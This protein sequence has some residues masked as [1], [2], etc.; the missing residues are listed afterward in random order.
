LAPAEANL[1]M[2]ESGPLR[3]GLFPEAGGRV[4]LVRRGDGPNLL[5][6]DPRQW[7]PWRVPAPRADAHFVPFNGHMTW[8]SPQSAW[9]SQQTV[10]E[11]RL[12]RKAAWPP[13]PFLVYGR[14]DVVSRE[15]GAAV[16][17]S[18]T[19][20]VTGLSMTHRVRLLCGKCVAF[21]AEAVNQR[22]SPVT[23]GLWSNTRVPAHATIVV[24]VAT[25]SKFEL[26]TN[27]DTPHPR[28][29]LP[30]RKV[31]DWLVIDGSRLPPPGT[32]Y[33]AKVKVRP[34][35]PII[36]AFIGDALLVKHIEPVDP[37]RIHRTHAPVEI[38]VERFRDPSLGVCELEAHGPNKE[39]KPGQ[40]LQLREHWYVA[41][42]SGGPDFRNRLQAIR[43]VA[44]T[45]FPT[46]PPPCI[47][48][49]TNGL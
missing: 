6:A 29:P 4:V 32:T 38:F 45:P 28:H 43:D 23:W 48:V 30:C 24:P 39:L 8:V 13:D 25:G 34:A 21:T 17:Q 1:V 33:A 2:L 10:N 37:D 3:V 42:Y 49:K 35:R 18:P 31:G 40:A 22:S 7:N 27:I 36:A 16:L 20:P 14:F 47:G 11:D 26:E 19:S 12:S 15:A 46:E 9:W 5:Q 44:L 41:D